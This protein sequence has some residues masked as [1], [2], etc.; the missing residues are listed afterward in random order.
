MPDADATCGHGQSRRMRAEGPTTMERFGAFRP[1]GWNRFATLL[2]RLGLGRGKLKTLL[3]WVWFRG[4]P[5]TV[6]DL[7]RYGLRWRLDFSDNVADSRILFSSRE[8]NGRELDALRRA[9]DAGL[10][11]DVGANIGYF[12]VRMAGCGSRVLAL[13]PN[14][15]AYRRMRRNISLNGLDDRVT[16]LQI[17]AGA[18]EGTATLTFGNDLGGGSTVHPS[19]EPNRVTIRTSPLADI[20]AAQG[21]RGIDA[22]KIDVEGAE[23]QVLVPF[24]QTAADEM[25]PRCIVIEDSRRLWK[26]DVID[27]LM[28]QGYRMEFR[29]R[30]NLVLARQ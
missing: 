22:L 27:M 3:E 2:V 13:E 6:A 14:P 9:C 10:F 4:R 25:R 30:S 17:G 26:T 20:V 18:Q 21:I 1:R 12:T 28:G 23:D 15:A 16:A 5:G 11:V 24:F 8:Y 7:S 19:P 29:T